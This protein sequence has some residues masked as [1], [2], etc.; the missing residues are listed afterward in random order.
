MEGPEQYIQIAELLAKFLK[1]HL[2]RQ[3]SEIV[4]SWIQ[5]NPRNRRLWEKLTNPDFL[6]NRLKYWRQGEDT[7]LSWRG[8]AAEIYADRNKT[9]FTIRRALSYAAIILPLLLACGAGWYILSHSGKKPP[10]A[11]ETG[12]TGI[13]LL[14]HGKVAR[15]ILGNGQI[16]NLNDSL[17]DLITE[18]DGTKLQ[19]QSSSIIYSAGDHTDKTIQ[20][21]NTLITPRGGEYQIR[22]SDGTKV[23]LNASSSLRYPTQFN[24]KERRIFL[25]G[26]AYF[27]V[28]KDADHPFVVNSG[29]MDLT[30]LGTRFNLNSYPDD[31]QQKTTL[32]EGSVKIS[33]LNRGVEVRDAVFLKPGYEAVILKNDAGIRVNAANVEAALAWKNGLFIFDNES[34]GAIMRRLSRWYDI[35]IKYD[36]K[37]DN[38][39][40]FT[41]RVQRYENITGILK[42]LELTGKV[43]FNLE[44]RELHVSLVKQR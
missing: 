35:D 9:R 3:E 26:E 12:L 34:V 31:P 8:L 21:Y 20:I 25:S 2:N 23:W 10:V 24:G 19:N 33:N 39:F 13:N 41:G 1:G 29:N 14:P 4:D 37:M 38:Q 18:K 17:H 44:N 42:L 30:V 43:H 6:E 16:L 27:E 15:L 36:S 32:A 7:E 22:L 28:A 11:R 40:H 5:E